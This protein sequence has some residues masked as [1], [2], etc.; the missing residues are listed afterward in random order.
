MVQIKREWAFQ[1]G[2]TP[3]IVLIDG[4]IVGKLYNGKSINLDLENGNHSLVFQHPDLLGINKLMT[5]VG[6][7]KLFDFSFQKNID[8]NLQL[9][10]S[11]TSWNRSGIKFIGQEIFPSKTENLKTSPKIHK[12][13]QA[14]GV[15]EYKIIENNSYLDVYEIIGTEEFP[16]D[17]SCGSEN[18]VIEHEFS[19]TVTNDINIEKNENL[20]FGGGLNFYGLIK[21]DIEKSFA[22]KIGINI[23]E[24]ITKKHSINLTIK[25]GERIKFHIIWKR[26]N[27]HG[28]CLLQIQDK[29]YKIPYIIKH[30]LAYEIKTEKY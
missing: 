17:N 11:A 23:G 22:K 24:T 4:E 27:S 9:T 10:F 18:I 21:S 14:I 28:E 20:I 6:I 7:M 30:D 13:E 25:Q 15:E 5:N 12:K 16:V 19:K 26:K 2:A 1:G 8:E 29:Q 3:W